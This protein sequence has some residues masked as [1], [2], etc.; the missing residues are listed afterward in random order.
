[1]SKN[2]GWFSVNSGFSK[3]NKDILPKTALPA[4]EKALEFAER[5]S[6]QFDIGPLMLRGKTRDATFSLFLPLY[7]KRSLT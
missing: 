5:F 2:E 7:K 4:W 3:V 1:L 6:E